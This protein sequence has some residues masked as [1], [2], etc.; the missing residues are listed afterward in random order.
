MS[1]QYVNIWLY[2]RE[3]KEE[4][5]PL[6]ES[7]PAPDHA[8]SLLPPLEGHTSTTTAAAALDNDEIER[9][10]MERFAR[11]DQDVPVIS[12]EVIDSICGVAGESC[13]DVEHLG[14]MDVQY[15]DTEYRGSNV[16]GGMGRG[17]GGGGGG[18][19]GGGGGGVIGGGGGGV[20]GGGG[21]GVLGGGGGGGGVLGGG[22]GGGGERVLG[23]GG[24]GGGGVLGGGGGGGGERVLGGGGGRVLGGG[25]G[26]GIGRGGAGGGGGG[27][28]GEVCCHIAALSDPKLTG[29]VLLERRS[30]H[31]DFTYGV[32]PRPQGQGMYAVVL[33]STGP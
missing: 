8:P 6:P 9:L 17:G 33:G 7:V 22:G 23:G 2:C 29:M 20:L 31:P 30:H 14:A 4:Q 21:G 16:R 11:L 26:G 27:S 19:L 32:K 18:V 3:V 13:S 1:I 5:R 12:S 10:E 25:G 24:V 15:S 28:T